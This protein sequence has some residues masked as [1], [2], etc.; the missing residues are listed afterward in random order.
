MQVKLCESAGGGLVA[1]KICRCSFYDP[2]AAN[3]QRGGRR[4]SL[5]RNDRLEAL[6]KE[7]SIM[8]RLDHPNIVK[9]HYILE[10][11]VKG[12]VCNL[13]MPSNL[14][15]RALTFVHPLPDVHGDGFRRRWICDSNHDGRG[16]RRAA[17]ERRNDA[18][19][20][21]QF[22]TLFQM[23]PVFFVALRPNSCVVR[24]FMTHLLVA[25][26]Y[27]HANGVVHRDVKPE[28]MLIR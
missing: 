18:Q 20:R 17:S 5:R 24:R 13:N 21:V 19:A 16:R 9:L 27:M 11:T 12:K 10:D 25:L 15:L 3:A 4:G 1:V 2:Q 7:I 26:S 14:K 28:N 8:K 22:T 23:P 6:K